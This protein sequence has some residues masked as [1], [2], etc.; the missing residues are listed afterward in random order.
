MNE[1]NPLRSQCG[2]STDVDPPR[3][4]ALAATCCP[5]V[6]SVQAGGLTKACKCIPLTTGPS[7]GGLCV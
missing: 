7:R 4:D 1:D 5:S 3:R 6:A 2:T